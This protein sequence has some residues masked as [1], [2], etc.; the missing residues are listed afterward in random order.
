MVRLC[1]LGL[2]FCHLVLIRGFLLT[3]TQRRSR[4]GGR[5]LSG[6]ACD[7]ADSRGHHQPRRCDSS[8]GITL[9]PSRLELT[10]HTQT[11]TALTFHLAS[12]LSGGPDDSSSEQRKGA[13][14]LCSLLPV[15][16]QMQQEPPS[17]RPSGGTRFTS[18]GTRPEIQ[19]RTA[20]A[21]R[22]RHTSM[23]SA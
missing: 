6:P 12:T 7:Y 14:R 10:P 17:P 4:T 13:E 2:A 11:R 15:Q 16:H 19:G 5:Q 18:A 9:T 21:R 3:Q 22:G 1:T 23:L 8:K 20:R